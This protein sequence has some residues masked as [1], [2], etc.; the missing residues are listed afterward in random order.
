MPLNDNNSANKEGRSHWSLLVYSKHHVTWYHFD[1]K[2][3]S[4]INHA[5]RL[6]CRVNSYLSDK[7]QPTFVVTSC[8]QQNNNYD[9]GAYSIVYGHKKSNGGKNTQ[10]DV[11]RSQSYWSTIMIYT[12]Q[13]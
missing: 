12:R 13:S 5:Y 8:I 1:S 9:F 3:C 7:T 10:Q 2:Q 11:V 6:L 4:N